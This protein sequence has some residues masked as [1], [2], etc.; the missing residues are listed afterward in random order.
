MLN[1]QDILNAAPSLTTSVRY[2]T[3]SVLRP[4]IFVLCVD[5]LVSAFWDYD[6]LAEHAF[7]NV[8][9]HMIVPIDIPADDEPHDDLS[10]PT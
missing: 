8:L 6:D 7:G 10:K 3:W 1:L 5:R 9:L 4:S 2:L